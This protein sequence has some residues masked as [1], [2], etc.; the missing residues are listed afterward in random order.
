MSLHP[1]STRDTSQPANSE[2]QDGLD[3]ASVGS[4][5]EKP[6]YRDEVTG[7]KNPLITRHLTPGPSQWLSPCVW[8]GG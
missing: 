8:R 4:S 1:T 3:A 5:S 2:A 6:R 7:R